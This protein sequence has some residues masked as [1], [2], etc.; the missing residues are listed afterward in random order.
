[1]NTNSSTVWWVILLASVGN[2]GSFE[3]H[4]IRCGRTWSSNQTGAWGDLGFF[5]LPHSDSSREG[6]QNLD[7]YI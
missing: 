1:M 7:W 3:T 5:Q 2:G 4:N 6:A